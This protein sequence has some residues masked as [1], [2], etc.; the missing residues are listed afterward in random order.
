MMNWA[1]SGCGSRCSSA[2]GGSHP[3]RPPGTP[4]TRSP[5][6]SPR[7]LAPNPAHALTVD[8]R[9]YQGC[10]KRTENGGEALRKGATPFKR[11]SIVSSVL[12]LRAN[13]C[14]L[15]I[16]NYSAG[17]HGSRR[18]HRAALVPRST[19]CTRTRC[20]R[21]EGAGPPSRRHWMVW[22]WKTSAGWSVRTTICSRS[23]ET[24]S[25]RLR[26][27]YQGVRVQSPFSV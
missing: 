5:A 15:L 12:R 10:I 13:I 14:Y 6:G 2:R 20:G 9:L 4:S 24:A 18:D 26:I 25:W 16:V 21:G 1:G 19:P 22:L 17:G 8:L 11:V 3:R 27:E 7:A 23:P